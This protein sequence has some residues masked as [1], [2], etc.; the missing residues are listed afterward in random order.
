M[1]AS[2]MTEIVSLGPLPEG[3]KEEL[4]EVR[5]HL[6]LVELNDQS[7]LGQ[8]YLALETIDQF[9]KNVTARK[10]L[11]L[12]PFGSGFR[13]WLDDAVSILSHPRRELHLIVPMP[14]GFESRSN[15]LDIG[16]MTRA[17]FHAQSL[18]TIDGRSL[19]ARLPAGTTLSGIFR[20]QAAKLAH[21]VQ[22]L[23]L[24]LS[25]PQSSD[26]LKE[27][28]DSFRWEGTWPSASSMTEH[29]STLLRVFEDPNIVFLTSRGFKNPERLF[30]MQHRLG[31]RQF[32]LCRGTNAERRLGA[33]VPTPLKELL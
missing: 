22:D 18:I 15:C 31:A 11:V 21:L 5:S 7:V 23:V 26:V 33:F 30:R 24:V 2:D 4:G 9:E 10:V 8:R 1:S 29:L 20:I 25:A 3:F 32:I 16:V 12:C 17:L 13:E 28:P 14:F 19:I 6:R 27:Y